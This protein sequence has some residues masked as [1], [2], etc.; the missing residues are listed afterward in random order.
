VFYMVIMKLQD[1]NPQQIAELS[2]K[3]HCSPDHLYKVAR[4]YRRCGRVL[5]E[6]IEAATQGSLKKQ[7]L[8]W[9]LDK[10]TRALA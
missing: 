5:A 1:F 9:P 6:K 10:K 4:G 3:I 8:I 2:L 7:D